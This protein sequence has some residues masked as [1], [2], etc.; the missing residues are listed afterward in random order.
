MISLGSASRT[1]GPGLSILSSGEFL[2]FLYPVEH[3][4]FPNGT[5]QLH[6]QPTR[7]HL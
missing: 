3:R 2:L 6:L 4:K 1:G 7:V 5:I